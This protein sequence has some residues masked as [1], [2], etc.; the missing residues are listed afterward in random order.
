MNNNLINESIANINY[1][2]N[3]T[4]QRV[5]DAMI[6]LEYKEFLMEDVDYNDIFMERWIYD[7]S[8]DDEV[9]VEAY[10][11]Y[12]FTGHNA[13]QGG[14]N[15]NFAKAIC[16]II[17]ASDDY[18]KKTIESE[19]SVGSIQ[20][21][22]KENNNTL[23]YEKLGEMVKQF[24]ALRPN[25][26]KLTVVSDDIGKDPRSG[27]PTMVVFI[28]MNIDGQEYWVTWHVM[29]PANTKKADN[30]QKSGKLKARMKSFDV[31]KSYSHPSF[32]KLVKNNKTDDT[33]KYNELE[34]QYS[35]VPFNRRGDATH[36]ALIEKF[37]LGKSKKTL[38]N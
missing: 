6:A 27:N 35:K 10:A 26:A 16:R 29:D 30:K 21:N 32:T 5:S 36:T 37:D 4:N 1:Y 2:V 22:G 14:R 38:F 20:M 17:E 25:F 8:D 34:K 7:S 33:A 15:L 23:K 18:H 28:E 13:D 11:D 9:F 19:R 31:L 24:V 3:D 12:D